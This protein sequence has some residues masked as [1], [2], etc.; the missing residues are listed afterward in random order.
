MLSEV[1]FKL[2]IYCLAVEGAFAILA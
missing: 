1:F 2:I